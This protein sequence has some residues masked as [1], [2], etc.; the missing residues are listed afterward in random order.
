MRI[1]LCKFYILK[2]TAIIAFDLQSV[3]SK[4]KNNKKMYNNFTN[5][6]S[7]STFEG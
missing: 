6:K 7:G 3:N 5:N 2:S 1:F 4:D